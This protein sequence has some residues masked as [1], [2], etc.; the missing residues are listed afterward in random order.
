MSAI[1]ASL[2]AS[3]CWYGHP[4]TAVA[5]PGACSSAV[6]GTAGTECNPQITSEMQAAI[7]AAAAAG[8]GTPTSPEI[9]VQIAGVDYA[10]GSSYDFGA[11][12]TSVTFTIQNIGGG[13]LN[14]SG[15]S[16]IAVSGSP[17]SPFSPA[18]PVPGSLTIQ[19]GASTTFVIN[20]SNETGTVGT[21]TILSN[22]ADESTYTLNFTGSCGT[23]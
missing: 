3:G 13:V 6:G 22:D 4:A 2:V 7:A 11:N 10:S 8:S 1:L 19:A 12:D 23:C 21:A 9:N 14:L 5:G 16:P 18:A 17:F 15:S 20:Y